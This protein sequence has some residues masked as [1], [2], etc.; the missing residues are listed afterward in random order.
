[1]MTQWKTQGILS[2]NYSSLGFYI[3]QTTQSLVTEYIQILQNLL[4]ELDHYQ[5]IEMKCNDYIVLKHVIKNERIYTTFARLNIDFNLFQMQVLGKEEVPSLNKTIVII[6]GEERQR[7]VMMEPQLTNG[8][9][10]VTKNANP[11]A[12]KSIQQQSNAHP[13]GVGGNNVL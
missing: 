4:Q 13:S 5:C 10:L 2:S 11:K 12:V 1:M 9:A 7:G 8:L 6:H 3:Y